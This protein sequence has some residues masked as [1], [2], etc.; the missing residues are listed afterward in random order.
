MICY[1]I[2]RLLRNGKRVSMLLY[3]TSLQVTYI[4]GEQV[5][6]NNLFVFDYRP[7][8]DAFLH[9]MKSSHG[10]HKYELWECEAPM[11][12]IAPPYIPTP[13]SVIAIKKFWKGDES[14]AMMATPE[15]CALTDKLTLKKKL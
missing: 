8:A 12:K 14:Q 9:A 15:G 7:S 4:P 2:V 13:Y 10:E 11:L 6:A 3:G 1:K 5:E